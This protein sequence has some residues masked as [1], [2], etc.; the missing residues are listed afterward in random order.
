[1]W[2]FYL[3]VVSSLNF[4][5]NETENIFTG[6]SDVSVYSLDSFLCLDALPMAC[7]DQTGELV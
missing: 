3:F 5:P 2:Q 6:A 4:V 1:M 7:M